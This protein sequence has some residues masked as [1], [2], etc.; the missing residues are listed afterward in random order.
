MS[1]PQIPGHLLS[2]L[3]E[4]ELEALRSG[5]VDTVLDPERVSPFLLRGAQ[6]ALRKREQEFRALVEN[7]PD[8]I[9]R[10]G[11]D[12]RF[13]YVNPAFERWM[14]RPAEE[15]HGRSCLDL[16]IP[17]TFTDPWERLCRQV[18]ETAQ[19]ERAELAWPSQGEDLFWSVRVVPEP[20][21]SGSVG[22]VLA[23]LRDITARRVSEQKLR[24][25]EELL[26]GAL[27][28][29]S[30]HIALL[31]SE[32]T[33][34]AVNAAW[35]RF[36]EENGW[37]DPQ[38]GVGTNYLEVIE[39]AAGPNSAE[40]PRVA[41]A[42][43][44]VA[45]GARDEF[46]LE[47]PCHSLTERRWFVTRVTPFRGEGPVRVAV[48]HENITERLLAEEALRES[49]ARYR[50]LFE[51]SMDGV[52]ITAPDGSIYEANPAAC[53]MLGYA[54][55][56]I[57]SLGRAGLVDTSDPRLPAALEQRRRTGQ[58]R[59]E[60]L[61]RRKD[62]TRVP[63][64]LST[65]IYQEEA[66][67]E[68]T[69][70]ILRDVSERK[71]AEDKLRA[72]EA[73]Y[74]RLVTTAPQGIY[75]LDAEGRFTEIN[76]AGEQLLGRTTAEVLGHPVAEIIAPLDL[77]VI[78]EAF[79]Q[80]ISGESDNL[81]VEVPILRPSGEE[82]VAAMSVTAIREE[83]RVTGVHGTARDLTEERRRDDRMRLLSTALD[84]LQEG[85][86]I[87]DEEMRI[88]YANAAY[89]RI[90][91]FDIA[92]P[93]ESG[94]DVFV[95]DEYSHEYHEIRHI[96]RETGSWRGL[97]RRKR[98]SD[99]RVIPLDI[100][101]GRVEQEGRALLF[102]ILQDATERIAREQ[103]LR[104]AERLASV[105]TML[106]GVAHELNNP[107]HAIIS[108]AQ[109]L[110]L[111]E[112]NAEDR[113]ALEIIRREGDRAAKIVSNLRLIARQTQDDVESQKNAVDLNEVV[114]HILKLRGYS[115]RTSNIEVREDLAAKLPPV[116]ADRSQ[117]EQVL[118]NL[119]I[120]AEQAMVGAKD[121][122]VLIVRTRP[123]RGGASVFVVDSGPGIPS[124][125]LE[126]I[127]DPFWTSKPTGEG[128]GLGLSLSQSIIAEHGGELRVESEFGKGAAFS[129][130]LPRAPTQEQE[131]GLVGIG[132]TAER[133]V[134]VLV[135]D[136]EPA[137]RRALERYLT[138]RGH[139][140]DVAADGQEALHL[141]T[142]CAPREEYEWI[143]SDLRMPGLGGD[144]L[145]ARLREQGAGLEQRLV[146][147][148]GDASNPDV[149]RMLSDFSAP[150]LLKPLRLEEIARIVESGTKKN[151]V[152]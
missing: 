114:R 55:E 66:G 21:G 62:G 60:L 142:A 102:L 73:H 87:I 88:V 32:G 26:D 5:E 24:Q 13:R 2:L 146:F 84:G 30:A 4:S 54:E 128:T 97:V 59:G 65:S 96:V 105:G 151:P 147:L 90:L 100:I 124:E 63:V 47:Y 53:A 40:G 57:R 3:T 94:I 138:R 133:S 127:F 103:H 31:D 29:L 52:M 16:P 80:V 118:L 121:E 41:A 116:L 58:F 76:P 134:R 35:K 136:D 23:I 139:K 15:I 95:P 46:A 36:A 107:L 61:L 48:V 110:L 8:L 18:F 12:L 131:H 20:T 72:A 68:R 101:I 125:Y 122:G 89:G 119:I 149:Q 38:F 137:V 86:G 43:R 17:V 112:R 70:M 49:E 77:D 120:N 135:V 19:E 98:L 37:Q 1:D 81:M 93:P 28:A 7:A 123:S 83:G 91:G 34:L 141:I 67:V 69:S 44:E 45:E 79:A 150:V 144:R 14:K 75:V 106:G 78:G 39:R 140:V 22:S 108:F 99:G 143:I 51:S 111:D 113:E 33:I 56:E 74:R 64:E 148:T 132:S 71:R 104:R 126:R 9:V 50:R 27:Q 115:L 152:G 109:L 10:L 82:R 85:V 42:I 25:S 145:L 129:V 11:H 117:I 6:E 92:H 130:D